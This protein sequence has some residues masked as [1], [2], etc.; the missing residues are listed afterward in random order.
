MNVTHLKLIFH[1]R[2]R[3][4]I[5]LINGYN[6]KYLEASLTILPLNKTIVVGSFWDL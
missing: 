4:R 5:I 6:N 2:P 1:D 3:L